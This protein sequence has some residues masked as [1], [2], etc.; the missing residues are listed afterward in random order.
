MVFILYKIIDKKLH[1]IFKDFTD[2][3]YATHKVSNVEKRT[4]P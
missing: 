1:V 3:I 2:S 4:I